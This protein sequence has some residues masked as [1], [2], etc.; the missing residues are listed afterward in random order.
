MGETN[1]GGEMVLEVQGLTKWYGGVAALRGLSL[2][3][4]RGAFYGLFGRNGAGKTTTL[5][6]VTGLLGRDAGHLRMFGQEIGLEPSPALKQRFAYVG[7]SV[8]LYDALTL[9]QHLDYVS[10]FY[11]TWD[12][13]RARELGGLFRLPWQQLVG[14]LSPGQHLQ[15]QLLMALAHHPELLLMDEPGNLDPVTRQRLMATMIDILDRR[16]S[17]IVMASH[18]ISE[19]EGICDHMCVVDR[20]TT[21]LAGPTAELVADVREVHFRGVAA[22]P[23][24]PLPDVWDP[25]FSGTEL[26]VVLP[27][28]TEEQAAALAQQVGA[29]G[30]E[31]GRVGL[32]EF[33]IALTAERE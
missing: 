14:T 26:H 33:F 3:V 8:G 23:V 6:C 18:L 1:P 5:D 24:A 11:A 21:L 30:Y 7:G 12:P 20:G 22:A 17:T 9:Q 16:E 13:E 27:H 25:R 32:E 31:V 28:F 2:A 19:L 29:T 4:P 10:G 15:F